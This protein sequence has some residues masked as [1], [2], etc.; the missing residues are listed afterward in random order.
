VLKISV[1]EKEVERWLRPEEVSI[2]AEQA[3]GDGV[4]L[5]VLVEK[6]HGGAPLTRRVPLARRLY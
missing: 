5:R 3:V 4:V 2:E 1:P 6:E